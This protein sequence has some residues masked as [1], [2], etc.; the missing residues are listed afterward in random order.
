[1]I[2]PAELGAACSAA[3]T[4]GAAAA[5]FNIT[6]GM[7]IFNINPGLSGHSAIPQRGD[8]QNVSLSDAQLNWHASRADDYR[9]PIGLVIEQAQGL[10]RGP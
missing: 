3:G 5:T 10:R 7:A 8:A 6:I 9:S 4:S 2:D 1:L